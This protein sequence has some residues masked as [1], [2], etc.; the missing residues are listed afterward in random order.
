MPHGPTAYFGLANVTMRHDIEG[1]TN[2]SEAYPHL[3]IDNLT[4]KI[5][6]RVATILK[7]AAPP[8]ERS[9]EETSPR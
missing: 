1:A 8:L 7:R 2:M 5:G 9:A 4:T 6:A 3:V